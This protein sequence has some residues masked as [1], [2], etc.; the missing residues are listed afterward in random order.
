MHRVASHRTT[1]H[2]IARADPDILRRKVIWFDSDKFPDFLVYIN[3]YIDTL[4][5]LDLS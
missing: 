3:I 2:R 5:G 4:C 1:P